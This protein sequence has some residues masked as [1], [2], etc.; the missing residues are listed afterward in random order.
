MSAYRRDEITDLMLHR[1]YSEFIEMPGLR[2]TCKQAQRLWGLDEP[3]CLWLL[4][5][6]V[7]ARFLYQPDRAA[8]ARLTDGHAEFPRPRTAKADLCEPGSQTAAKAV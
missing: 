5:S 4:E 2:L 8:Y 7:E 6:L 1:V 3:T